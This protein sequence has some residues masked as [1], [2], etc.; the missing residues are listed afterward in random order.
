M[1]QKKIVVIEWTGTLFTLIGA[2]L[3]SLHIDPYN[4]YI[5]N[6]GSLC[7]VIWAILVKRT[8][9]LIVNLGLLIIYFYGTLI[10]L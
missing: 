7:W 9:I 6:I 4:V 8:S 3:T 2:V 5:L 1:K 10:R